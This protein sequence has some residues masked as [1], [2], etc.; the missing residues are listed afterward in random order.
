M[1]ERRP[2]A[3][4]FYRRRK[5]KTSEK[6]DSP[7]DVNPE[8]IYEEQP[9]A[10][11]SHTDPADFSIEETRVYH[12][13]Q[14]AYNQALKFYYFPSL[15]E[16]NYIFDY[17]KEKGFFIEPDSWRITLNLANTP[18]IHLDQE[19]ID[20]FHALSL[21]EIGHYHWCPYDNIT[22][23]R[24]L[25]AAIEGGVNKFYAPI[26]TNIFSDLLID[27]RIH[28]RFPEKMEWE[29]AH[30]TRATLDEQTDKPPSGLWLMLVRA[31]EIMWN[32]KILPKEMVSDEINSI[33]EKVSK[34]ILKNF[35]DESEWAKKVKAIGRLL[36]ELLRNNCELNQEMDDNASKPSKSGG[37]GSAPQNPFTLP[38]D[39]LDT[40]GDLT[41]IRQPDSIKSGDTGKCK[42]GGPNSNESSSAMEEFAAE[43][44]YRT[45]ADVMS[46]QGKTDILDN[47]AIWYRGL[48]K[49]LLS[50]RIYTHKPGGSIPLYPIVWKIGDPME[51]LDPI[52]SILVSPVLIPNITTRKWGFQQGEGYLVQKG[53]PDMMIVLDSSGS[54]TWDINSKTIQGRYHVA[55]LA[56]FAALHYAFS[57]GCYVAAINFSSSVRTEPWTNNPAYLERILLQYQGGGTEMPLRKIKELARNHDRHSLIIII[58][59]LEIGNWTSTKAT[60][61]ELLALGN[62]VISFFIDGNPRVLETSDFQEL[63]ELGAKFFCVDDMDDLAGLVISEVQQQ[64][65]PQL[66]GE[67]KEKKDETQAFQP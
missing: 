46:L 20:Y 25:G 30:T 3:R 22:N 49:N 1:E 59:D 13:A 2:K 66:E 51:E 44:N 16:P 38:E 62:K 11:P 65:E 9:V 60:I 33:A 50:I 32:K 21:H 58:S 37:Q 41:E 23:Y 61:M 36:K 14:D 53:L 4:R 10:I 18:K 26:V 29:M 17:T 57:H 35:E 7:S 24:L 34:I 6:G 64:Y 47:M 63:I 12:L 39:V 43:V 31:Y 40:F 42:S 8:P 52:Q 54:M 45:F 28:E 67:G 15:P 48:A 19:Y 5:K 56:S 27:Y 55:L